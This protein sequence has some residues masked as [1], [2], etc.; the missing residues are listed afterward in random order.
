MSIITNKIDALPPLPSTITELEDFRTSPNKDPEILL[1]IIEKD[2]LTISTLLKVANSA[3]FAFRSKVETP[4]RAISLLG[5]NFTISV[6]LGSSMQN[7]L[8]TDLRAYGV[9]IEQFMRYSNLIAALINIWTS[10]ISKELKEELTIPAFLQ[11]IGKLI[12]AEIAAS[13][14]KTD[15]FYKLIKTGDIPVEVV[16]KKMVGLSSSEITANIF[17][18]WKL[19]ENL[20][21]AIEF[22]DDIQK[23][24]P[25][26]LQKAQILK[27]AK[28]ACTIT[29][30]LSEKNIAKAFELAQ[31]FGL[32]ITKL[33]VAIDKLQERLLD[34]N[35]S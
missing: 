1:K 7:I 10:S 22:V 12:I 31:E 5:V 9:D 24:H 19:S 13:Y 8:K 29:D 34:E 28:T 4:S 6:A 18:H 3:M 25:T 27:V 35:E 26:F 11:D 16:E 33:E 17:K 30:P 20:I 2:P 15:A 21:N 14:G 32:D 23:V